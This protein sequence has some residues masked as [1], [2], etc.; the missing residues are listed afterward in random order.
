MMSNGQNRME[1][2]KWPEWKVLDLFYT[3]GLLIY[4]VVQIAVIGKIT[5][6][7]FLLLL[8]L[9]TF[10]LNHRQK[11]LYDT[12]SRSEEGMNFFNCFYTQDEKSDQFESI[13]LKK[14]NDCFSALFAL[15]FCFVMWQFHVWEQVRIV[16]SVFIMFLF[17]ANIPT[18]LAIIRLLKYFYHSVKWIRKIDFGLGIG[19]N[20]QARFVRKIR[21]KV[22]FTAATYCTVSLISIFFTEIE[23]NMIVA[24]YSIFA[25]I[26]ILLSLTVTDLM[27]ETRR[28]ESYYEALDKINGNI[29]VILQSVI[30][31]PEEEL[32]DLQK[33]IEIK[34]LLNK[35]REIKFDFSK[36]VSG[37]GLV[38]ITVLPIMLQYLMEHLN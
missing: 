31:H 19:D 12:L 10:F 16:K 18:G 8:T 28:K 24:L 22:L 6:L 1:K 26:L 33:M 25:V 38:L 30:A 3:F 20:F 36:L 27:I 29:S 2:E 14:E 17:T 9:A 34:D 23:L 5:D 15:I 11:N 21:G 7:L 37:A 13:F 35:E 32:D 4:L